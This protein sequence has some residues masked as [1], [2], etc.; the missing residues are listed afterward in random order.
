MYIKYKNT[1][2]ITFTHCY[3]I[4]YYKYYTLYSNCKYTIYIRYRV[5]YY[6]YIF[7]NKITTFTWHNIV[8]LIR[9]IGDYS[10]RRKTEGTK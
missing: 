8:T 3:I 5:L 2:D 1:K 4:I 7:Y 9:S 6:I 10:W